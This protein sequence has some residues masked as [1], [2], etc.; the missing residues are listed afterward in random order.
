MTQSAREV[1]EAWLEGPF[2]EACDNDVM[3]LRES[4]WMLKVG[5]D[6]GE[7]LE[8]SMSIAIASF[9]KGLIRGETMPF[10]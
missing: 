1:L 2:R 10:M 6:K 3:R 9:V 4:L 7:P 8:F 5:H